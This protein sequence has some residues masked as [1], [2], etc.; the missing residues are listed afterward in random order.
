MFLDGQFSR[1]PRCNTSNAMH[2]VISRIKEAWHVGK[3]V[4]AIFLNI[5]GAFSNTAKDCLLHNM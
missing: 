1:H 3:V 5:Q 2:L 4:T